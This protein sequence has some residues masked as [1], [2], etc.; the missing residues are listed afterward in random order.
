[1][2]LV[3]RSLI[4]GATSAASAF[5]SVTT[6]VDLVDPS[7]GITQPPLGII[8]IDVLVD[9]SPDD[10]WAAAGT[11]VFVTPAG[12]ADGVQL[13]YAPPNEPNSPIPYPILN[14]G[15][16]HRFV[17]FLSQ[18]SPRDADGRYTNGSVAVAGRYYPGGGG[19]NPT[20]TPTEFNVAWVCWPPPNANSPSVDGAI[21]RVAIDVSTVLDSHP[22][23]WFEVGDRGDAAGPIVV[24]S[25]TFE[26]IPGTVSAS[27]DVPTPR[28]IDWAVW[29]IPEPAPIAIFLIAAVALRSR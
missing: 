16:D 2:H 7:D 21:A 10:V 3:L 15:V 19:P 22:G 1:M 6:T 9:V 12:R 14:P 29:Y 4:A 27:F 5:A 23:A 25:A 11:R 8:A 20:I 17:T 26:N 28:G 24:E 18:P 13:I